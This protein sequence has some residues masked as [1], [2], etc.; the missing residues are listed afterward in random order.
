MKQWYSLTD[1]NCPTEGS[2]A[3]DATE[4]MREQARNQIRAYRRAARLEFDVAKHWYPMNKNKAEVHARA[5]LQLGAQTYWLAELTE[6]A[7]RE[8]RT[9]HAMG[10]WT[11]SRFPCL[12]TF[13]NGQYLNSCPVYVADLRMG[14]SPGFTAKKTCAI[15]HG[16]LSECIHRRGRLYWVRGGASN[17]NWCSVCASK[18]CKHRPDRLYLTSVI[19]VIEQIDELHEISLVD[20]PAQPLARLTERPI[21]GERLAKHF[22]PSFVPGITVNCGRCQGRYPGLPA[23]LPEVLAEE[24]DTPH[25]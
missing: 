9:L 2:D 6:L 4:W 3:G 12:L 14:L 25:D 23:E 15:C 8:H 19:G 13:K 17:D 11:S 24:S 10:R 20:V 1:P 5:A 22:G 7:E 21:N 16:D 18:G